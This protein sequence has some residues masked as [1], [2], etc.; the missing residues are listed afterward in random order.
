MARINV[1]RSRRD[2]NPP[3]FSTVSFVSLIWDG[4]NLMA[5]IRATMASGNVIRNT[6]PHELNVRRYPESSGPREAMAAPIPDHRAI[7]FVRLGPDHNAAINAG[8]VGN[9]IPAAKPPMMRPTIRI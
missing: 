2:R 7:D 1:P 9:A 8:V 3:M 4:T 6:E 5:M